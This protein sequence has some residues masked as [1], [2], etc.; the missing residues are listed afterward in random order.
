MDKEHSPRS[1]RA[2]E[3]AAHTVFFLCALTAVAG[4]LLICL[5]LVVTGLP[6]IWS[7]GVTDFLFGPVWDGKN[8]TF[9][10]LPFLLT[11]L[12]G[13]AG[14]L[15]L[16]APVGVLTALFLAKVAKGPAAAVI[17]AA[18]S[19]LAGIP[20]VV[21]GLVGL[22]VLVPALQRLFAL[23][24]GATLLAAILVLAVMILPSVI[25][26]AETA[27][28]SVPREYEEGSL[29]LGAT[30]TQTMFRVSLP[31]A[32]SGVTAAFVLG[33]GRAMGE[34]MAVLMV[35]GNVANLPTSLFLP[36]RFLTTA[37]TSEMSYAT[38]GSLWKQALLSIGLV[39]FLLI[40][41]LNGA[42]HLCLSRGRER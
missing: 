18:V 2:A 36:V 23:T 5:Y 25:H 24:S 38:V 7:I 29:A 20:S 21:Y 15:L 17:R 1:R 6:A 19:L 33:A 27:L 14:A 30:Q 41:L 37:I 13:T 11:S 12:A 4:V 42:L 3:G 8:G 26:M 9:G 16:G 10:I 28:R 35:S 31:A 22:V 39:L 40:L 34:A 32:R